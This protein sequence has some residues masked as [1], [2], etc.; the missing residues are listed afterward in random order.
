V[1]ET[2]T[3]FVAGG[4]GCAGAHIVKELLARNADSRIRASYWRTQPFLKDRRLA[5]CRADLRQLRDCLS[6][7]K[8]CGAAVLAA[9][10]GTG[11]GATAAAQAGQITDNVTMNM[12]LLQACAESGVQRVIYVGSASAYQEAQR[13]LK[14]DEMDLCAD[15]PAA[16]LGIGWGMRFI[17]KLCRFWHQRTGMD[18]VIV[19]ATNIFGPFAKF[20][21]KVSHVIPALIRKAVDRQDPFE[22]WGSADVTRDV[23][24]AGDFAQ[25]IALMLEKKDLTF[26]VFNIGS[27]L[28]V[29][30]G[31][32]VAWILSAADHRPKNITYAADRPVS[33]RFRAFDTQHSR[34]VL[35]W[36]PAQGVPAGIRETVAWWRANRKGWQR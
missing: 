9:G 18:V 20:D 32:L 13:S 5:Y 3:V 36:T 27:G 22:V 4:T 10:S 2:Q 16:F 34:D 24:Y 6:A 29:K 28:P 23:V 33:V 26:D 17:E 15:P 31:D 21:P 7:V 1:K 35:G 30:V 8:G 19:R 25:A 11:A 12:N 14:E